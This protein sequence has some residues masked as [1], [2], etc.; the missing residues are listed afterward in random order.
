[1]MTIMMV[2]VRMMKI[3][4][5]DDDDCSGTKFTKFRVYHTNNTFMRGL[6]KN[7][8]HDMLMM[9]LL[10]IKIMMVEMIIKMMMM[11]V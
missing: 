11:I 10:V 5:I 1:M 4:M 8:D 6:M 3:L 7:K 2:V 9:T